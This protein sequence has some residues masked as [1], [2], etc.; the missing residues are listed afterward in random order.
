MAFDSHSG[1]FLAFTADNTLYL[2]NC[3]DSSLKAKFSLQSLGAKV[4]WHRDEHTKFMVA[5]TSGLI[6]IYSL[7][8]SS[9]VYSLLCYNESIKR[10]TTPILSFDWSQISP[11][12]IVANTSNEILLWNTSGSRYYKNFSKKF[13]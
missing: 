2:W 9:P 12:I 7:E 1:E 11:E 8:T 6:R 4:C 10:I 5:E 3:Q 13:F